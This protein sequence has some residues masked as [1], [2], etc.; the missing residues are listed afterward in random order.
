[1]DGRKEL[2]G[3]MPRGGRCVEIGSWQGDFAAQILATTRP[4]EL[5]VVDPWTFTTAYG[6]RWYGG[7]KA[8]SQADMDAI[9]DAVRARFAGDPRVR[10]HRATSQVAAASFP[11]RFFDW[12]YIDGNHYEE[13]VRGDLEGYFPKVRPGGF[14][15]G[16]DYR[17]TSPELDGRL[18]V[19]KA[20]DEFVDRRGLSLEVIGS[21]Y[22]IRVPEGSSSGG[23]DPRITRRG[24][25]TP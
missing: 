1:M 4:A 7:M 25:D 8:T 3:R 11:D 2:L 24:S 12:V 18:P 15:T 16:D 17:W 13:F 23:S 5:H 9:H 6:R 10:I 14:V 22:I 20:V 21:Q 19:M